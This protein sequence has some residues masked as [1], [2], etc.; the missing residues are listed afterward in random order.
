MSFGY[1]Y[2]PYDPGWGGKAQ[3]GAI[4]LRDVTMLRV[5]P[6]GNLGILR[7]KARCNK[8]SAH[9][10]GRAW[11]AAI[12]PAAVEIPVGNM[13]ANFW[14]MPEVAQMLGIQRV[15]WG[16]GSGKAAKEWDSRPGQRYW[17][18]YAGPP[19]DEH[20]H[21][22][23]AW[24]AARRLT[25]QQVHAAYDMYWPGGDD[26]FEQTDRIRLERVEAALRDLI[27]ALGDKNPATAK[28]AWDRL[29]DARGD[30]L[31]NVAED[32]RNNAKKAAENTE[33]EG[34]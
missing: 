13:L 33:P 26:M 6:V 15:I 28:A 34:P 29:G 11:D 22:E 1:L 3:P 4:A 9:C 7:D 10:H 30:S 31:M 2:D 25:A 17:S 12:G 5:P 27:T 8:A 20:V 24:E 21:V 16:F 23:L 18:S 19:H 32:A 14:V